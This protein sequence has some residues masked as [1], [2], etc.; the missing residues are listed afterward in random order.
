[1]NKPTTPSAAI[2]GEELHVAVGQA[3]EARVV[4]PEQDAG[5]VLEIRH[6]ASRDAI[7]DAERVT[8]RKDATPAAQ[9]HRSA[10]VRA[11]EGAHQPLNPDRRIRDGGRRP[12]DL[13]EHH[14]LRT[15]ALRD[16]PEPRR[17]HLQRLVPADPLPA[18]VGIALRACPFQW[19]EQPIRMVDKFRR[20]PPLRAERLAGR[21]RR[22]RFQGD[23]AAVFDAGD[24]ATP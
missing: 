8:G 22:I 14:A 5:G 9:L 15:V 4:A 19:I 1:M 12:G 20:R 3:G 16:L 23:K 21:M 10:Q 24:R 6:R 13:A 18:R 11:A 17:R 2:R 7:A